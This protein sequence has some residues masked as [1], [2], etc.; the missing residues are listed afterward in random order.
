METDT[1]CGLCH[2]NQATTKVYSVKVCDP[3]F[4]R[5]DPLIR[6]LARI[7]GPFADAAIVGRVRDI[8]EELERIGGM[9]LMMDVS[10]KASESNRMVRGFVGKWWGGI[11]DWAD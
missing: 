8:G 10:M 1:T 7:V 5:V 9:A 3:C 2:Q 6:E 4:D 11:G